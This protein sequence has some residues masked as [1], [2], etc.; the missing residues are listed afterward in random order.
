MSWRDGIPNANNDV[1][2]IFL[3][4]AAPSQ[5]RDYISLVRSAVSFFGKIAL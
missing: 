1:L 5:I 2:V 3:E 4:F